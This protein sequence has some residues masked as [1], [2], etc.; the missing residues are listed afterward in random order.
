MNTAEMSN[1]DNTDFN[2]HTKFVSITFFIE[3][4]VTFRWSLKA[5]EGREVENGQKV[6]HVYFKPPSL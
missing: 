5:L 1:S 3:R 2:S 6:R 4:H